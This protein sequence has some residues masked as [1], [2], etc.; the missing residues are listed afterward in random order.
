MKIKLLFLLLSFSTY[1][2]IPAY[3][4]SIDF[5]QTGNTLKTQLASLITTNHTTQLPY[6]AATTDVWDALQAGD[7][8]PLNSAQVLLIYG[9]NDVDAIYKNDRLDDVTNICSTLCPTGAWNREHCY[10][11]SLGTPALVTSSAGPGTDAHHIRAA[12]V[13]FNA[14]RG[15]RLYADGE[16][17]AGPVGI[18]W[19]PGDE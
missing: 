14:D 18:Y 2:Q 6:T 19:Y 7:K 4:S 8:N 1:A 3:Y 15:N 9:Y 16:G 10:A 12:D 5:T 11:L 13:T 17:D